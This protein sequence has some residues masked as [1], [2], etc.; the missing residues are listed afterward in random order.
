M[1]GQNILWKMGTNAPEQPVV[2]GDPSPMASQG[3]QFRAI[4]GRL[5]D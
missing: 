4:L 1:E 2:P 3:Q 5:R